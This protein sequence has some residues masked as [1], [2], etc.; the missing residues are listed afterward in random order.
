MDIKVIVARVAES[1]PITALCLSCGDQWTQPPSMA[2][3]ELHA[4]SGDGHIIRVARTVHDIL[5]LGTQVWAR[6]IPIQPDSGR[7]VT[8]S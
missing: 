3:L 2:E 1:E 7:E 4:S 8:P 6:N 5:T